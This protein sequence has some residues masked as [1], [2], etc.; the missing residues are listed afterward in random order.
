MSS[1]VD[2]DSLGQLDAAGSDEKFTAMTS[3]VAVATTKK[4]LRQRNEQGE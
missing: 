1:D 4:L 3:D 2:V